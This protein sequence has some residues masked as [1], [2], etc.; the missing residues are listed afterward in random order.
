[1]TT[2]LGGGPG[3][4]VWLQLR[5][6]RRIEAISEYLCRKRNQNVRIQE[7]GKKRLQREESKRL[8]QQT[9]RQ[10]RTPQLRTKLASA[11]LPGT[12]KSA[13]EHPDDTA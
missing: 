2:S 6:E 11:I 12:I 1:M 9:P 10:E 13:H 8:K 4:G 3:E 7:I 5:N